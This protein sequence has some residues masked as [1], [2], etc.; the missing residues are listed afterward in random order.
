MKK[1]ILA[2]MMAAIM[3]FAMSTTAFAAETTS[4]K[5]Y[6]F[7]KYTSSW[8]GSGSTNASGWNWGGNSGW[9]NGFGWNWGGSNKPGAGGNE[10]VEEDTRLD[11]PSIGECRY[12]HQSLNAPDCLVVD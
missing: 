8:G 2:T 6:G 7:S 12:I 3:M 4:W 5:N 9:G 11:A 1:R 10:A